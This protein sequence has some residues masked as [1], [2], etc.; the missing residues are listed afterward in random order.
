LKDIDGD[1]ST[2]IREAA[3]TWCRGNSCLGRQRV[4]RARRAVLRRF[5]VADEIVVLERRCGEEEDMETHSHERD[6]RQTTTR[7]A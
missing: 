4:R 6:E 1:D 5:Q 2:G 3:G 7:S